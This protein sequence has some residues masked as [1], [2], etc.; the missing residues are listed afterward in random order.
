MPSVVSGILD[1]YRTFNRMSA[2]EVT[3]FASPWADR[4]SGPPLDGIVPEESWLTSARELLEQYRQAFWS[5]I[6]RSTLP[7]YLRDNRY[8]RF[9]F[10]YVLTERWLAYA[11]YIHSAVHFVRDHPLDLLIYCDHF[12]AEGVI[13]ATLYRRA[14]TRTAIATHSLHA[15]D[16]PFVAWHPEDSAIVRSCFSARQ[17]LE[18][19]GLAAAYC[20]PAGR[21]APPPAVEDGDRPRRILLLGNAVEAPQPLVDIKAY[22]QVI[23]DLARTPSHLSGRVELTVRLK[24]G[25]FSEYPEVHCWFYG[26]DPQSFARAEGLSLEQSIAQADCVVGTG[27]PTSAYLEVLAQDKPLLH[28][29]AEPYFPAWA[30]GFP[31][32]IEGCVIGADRLWT[33]IEEVLFDQ[34]SRDRRV[35]RQR[36]Y[37][38]ADQAPSFPDAADPLQ[39]AI[40]AILSEPR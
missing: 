3:V 8:L 37:F 20:V 40:E 19:G 7:G 36:A 10:D 24:P 16:V 39:A 12:I 11:R 21:S 34:A 6:E 18:K 31:N 22:L 32:G 26:V 1:Y 35:A 27:I 9:Q 4:P 30:N 17:A 15:C 29:G 28:V 33:E 23:A 5:R 14:G 38:A 2:D 25:V 13:L